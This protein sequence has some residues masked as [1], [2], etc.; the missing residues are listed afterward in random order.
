MRQIEW[1]GQKSLFDD[2]RVEYAMLTG[3]MTPQQK[4]TLR[5]ATRWR[6]YRIVGKSIRTLT[7]AMLPGLS[8]SYRWGPEKGNYVQAVSDGDAAIILACA[9][10]DEFRDV[11][12]GVPPEMHVPSDV[13]QPVSVEHYRDVKGFDAGLRRLA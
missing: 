12:H 7:P 1:T 5:A 4:A 6:V 3:K 13:L 11:T 8:K 10:R 2:P 9:S